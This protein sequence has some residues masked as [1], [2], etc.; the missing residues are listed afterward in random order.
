MVSFRVTAS[1]QHLPCR[2]SLLVRSGGIGTRRPRRSLAKG[3]CLD[4]NEQDQ[5]GQNHD[6]PESELPL[7][8][9]APLDDQSH[10]LRRTRSP[11]TT[12]TKQP[13]LP[14]YLLLPLI[15][16][17]L[18]TG[19][20]IGI[21]V[22]PPA[23]RYFLRL[24]GMKPGG[25]T[26]NPIAVPI[27]SAA[28]NVPKQTT[29]RSVVALGR[30]L[31]DGK[32]ITISPPYGAGDARIEEIKV[33]IGSQVRRGDVLAL[34]D[35]NQSLEAA[36][37]SAEANVA[38]QKAALEQTRS[39]IAAS[40][41][42]AKAVLERAKTGETLADQELK[43]YQSLASKGATSQSETDQ[44]I[45]A[46]LQAKGDV[47]KAEATLRRYESQA[48]DDQPDVVVAARTLDSAVADLNRAKRDMARGV[49]TAPVS[50]TVLDIYAR[51]GEKPG[52]RGILDL[53]NIQRMTAD[54]EVYQSEISSVLVGQQVELSADAFELPFHGT[55][56]EIGYSVQRQTVVE[57]DPAANTDARIVVVK[58]NLDEESSKRAAKLTNLEVTGRIAVEDP[59]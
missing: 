55:V 15:P 4:L 27:E 28:T 52:A 45:A 37:A 59:K 35:N 16:L 49:V 48:I 11:R 12:R 25:G 22:Q 42:E 57:D 31:P 46:S 32:V 17:L 51:P 41:E 39:S 3:V 18:F 58:V 19:A 43:R 50:G 23:L 24:T 5:S 38:L 47:A 30:L 33:A 36:V 7:Q 10:V 6:V 34:L 20:V 29:I 26:S 8:V 56:S 1:E 14:K 53:G 44:A 13:A 40:L 54:L 2:V 21:Y 9:I